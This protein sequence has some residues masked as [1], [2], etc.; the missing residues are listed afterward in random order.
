MDKIKGFLMQFIKPLILG[1][2]Q[3]LSLLT[4]LFVGV[5]MSK[6]NMPQDQ[7]ATVAGVL[8]DVTEKE[9]ATLINKL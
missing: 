3:D 9:L 2:L 5:L 1:H 6:L 7:A 8:V 4:P